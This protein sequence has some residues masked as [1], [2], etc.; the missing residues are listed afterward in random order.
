MILVS[1]KTWP[2]L[3]PI[4]GSSTVAYSGKPFKDCIRCPARLSIQGRLPKGSHQVHFVGDCG[5]LIIAG[6]T[7]AAV[8]FGIH[9]AAAQVSLPEARGCSSSLGPVAQHPLVRRGSKNSET[10]KEWLDSGPWR[11]GSSIVKTPVAIA[12][13]AQRLVSS[14]LDISQVYLS[15]SLHRSLAMELTQFSRWRFCGPNHVSFSNH[16]SVYNQSFDGR[17]KSTLS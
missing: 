3:F 7:L 16:R 17:S 8:G 1:P 4:H 5:Y 14:L 11:P 9:M 2:T 13:F 12:T 15:A 6:P 10:V